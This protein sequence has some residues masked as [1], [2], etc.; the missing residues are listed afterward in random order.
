LGWRPEMGFEQLVTTM[1]DADLEL[2]GAALR[3]GTAY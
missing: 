2:Q 1:V 3:S